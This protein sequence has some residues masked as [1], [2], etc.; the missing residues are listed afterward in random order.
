MFERIEF[1][2]MILNKRFSNL[3]TLSGFFYYNDESILVPLT[4]QFGLLV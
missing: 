2:S 3:L 4:V 1:S